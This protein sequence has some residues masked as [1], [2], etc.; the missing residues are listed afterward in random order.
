[1][2]GSQ[3]LIAEPRA[4]VPS[5][6]A[7][8]R[9]CDSPSATPTTVR[10]TVVVAPTAPTVPAPTPDRPL[11]RGQPEAIDELGLLVRAQEQVHGRV[12]APQ[13]GP[14]RLAHGAAGQ[15]D[16]QPGVRGL[17][18]SEM[19]LPPDDLLLGALADGAGVDDDQV[20]VV[21]RRRLGATGG[22][23]STGHLLRVA[24]V[25]LAAQRP[26]VEARQR[27][28]LGDVLG[29][30]VVDRR[31]RRSGLG[32]RTLG[33]AMSST[34]SARFEMRVSVTAAPWYAEVPAR[35]VSS[36]HG[37]C[38]PVH[39]PRDVGRPADADRA[40]D[41][42]RHRQRHLHLDPRPAAARGAAG[43]G[44]ASSASGWRWACASCCC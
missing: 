44:R 26:D 41:R 39:Q 35:P 8:A 20:G 18:P 23:E 9:V 36:V 16:P 12:A 1:M 29:E 43:S 24:A 30:A 28:E 3:A 7:R 31:G 38:D 17:E 25:H 34:G 11:R 27:R 22:E 40:R 10:P 42:A 19:A 6:M 13:P 14:V 2:I 21:H 5:P 32:A 33:G 37:P 15:H 4:T